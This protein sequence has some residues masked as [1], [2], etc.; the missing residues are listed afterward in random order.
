MFRQ[1]RNLSDCFNI[2]CPLEFQVMYGHDGLNASVKF[3]LLK[4]V[5][6]I[7]R[8][9]PCLPVVAIIRSD[10]KSDCRENKTKAFL[11]KAKLFNVKR[12]SP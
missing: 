3:P 10:R 9:Q 11:K 7:Y 6:Q 2:P 8:Y 4:A 5:I 12:I 1:S